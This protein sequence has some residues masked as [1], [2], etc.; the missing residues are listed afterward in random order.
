MRQP[1][2]DVRGLFLRLIVK[3]VLG[4]VV[5]ARSKSKVF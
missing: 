5:M 4:E 2:C 1:Q 3:H